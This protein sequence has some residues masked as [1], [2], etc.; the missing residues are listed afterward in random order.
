MARPYHCTLLYKTS[1]KTV[2]SQQTF[3]CTFI[4][5]RNR[6]ITKLTSKFAAILC[7][8]FIPHV[9]FTIRVFFII[10]HFISRTR[11]TTEIYYALSILLCSRV[12]IQQSDTKNNRVSSYSDDL[13][14]MIGIQKRGNCRLSVLNGENTG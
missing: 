1:Y 8:R 5:E 14:L 10:L 11:S 4:L 6:N 9:N 3:M 13:S 7:I 12:K 2:L